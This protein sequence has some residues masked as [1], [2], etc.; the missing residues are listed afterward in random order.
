MSCQIGSEE[1]PDH[2]LAYAAGKLPVE[3]AAKL[4]LHMKSC[5]ECAAAGKA[6]KA[7]WNVLD[8]WQPGPVS[9]DFDRRLYARI[10]AAESASMVTRIVRSVRELFRPVLAQPAFAL[11]AAT[12]VIV[13]GFVLDHPGK[14]SI[15][16]NNHPSA[17]RVDQAALEQV[18]S[19]LDDIDMLHQFDAGSDESSKS[20]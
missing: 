14:M 11:S 4:E 18:E 12:L 2:L 19:T 3:A 9:A 15:S 7:V 5:A 16:A 20:M 10:E 8:A 6:Q 17:I 1:H 13:A